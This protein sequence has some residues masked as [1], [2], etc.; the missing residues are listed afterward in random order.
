MVLTYSICLSLWKTTYYE[1]IT[2][3]RGYWIRHPTPVNHQ[4]FSAIPPCFLFDCLGTSLAN[5]EGKITCK[6]EFFMRFSLLNQTK[7]FT[8]WISFYFLKRIAK[9]SFLHCIVAGV[10]KSVRIKKKMVMKKWE[11]SANT[12]SIDV[13]DLFLVDYERCRTLCGI[14]TWKDNHFWQLLQAAWLGKRSN[15]SKLSKF[16]WWE[17]WYTAAW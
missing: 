14:R 3:E 17:K 4:G 8:V 13:F 7:C 1:W 15:T 5:W 16:G 12:K 9:L 6:N 2:F 10:D 11:H